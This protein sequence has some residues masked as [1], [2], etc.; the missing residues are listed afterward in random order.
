MGIF[1]DMFKDL[2]EMGSPI[3]KLRIRLADLSKLLTEYSFNKSNFSLELTEQK[4]KVTF[5]EVL[6]IADKCE[7]SD[8]VRLYFLKEVI[9]VKVPIVIKA[10]E[11]WV[12]NVLKQQK[13]FT[14]TLAVQLID[15]AE[16]DLIKQKTNP[17]FNSKQFINSPFAPHF[18]NFI[19]VCMNQRGFSFYDA[20]IKHIEFKCDLGFVYNAILEQKLHQGYIYISIHNVGDEEY[21]FHSNKFIGNTLIK[22][23]GAY[24]ALPN[25]SIAYYVELLDEGLN[26]WG[27]N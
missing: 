12:D 3:A 21:Q 1:K 10:A 6:E 14:N 25:Q 27:I 8:K 26:E 11:Y 7:E 18:S 16:K 22:M 24:H 5:N 17:V 15:K 13:H 23:G 19:E 4:I 2:S 9:E 20:D